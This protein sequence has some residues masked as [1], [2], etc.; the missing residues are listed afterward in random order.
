MSSIHENSINAAISSIERMFGKGIVE[1]MEVLEQKETP[2]PLSSGSVAL[3]RALGT[4]GFPRGRFVELYG[5]EASGKTVLALHTI[6]ECQKQGGRCAFIDVDHSLNFAFA[7][8]IG[9]DASKLMVVRPDY[10]EQALEV[11][12]SLARSG[13]FALI[14]LDSIGALVP[15]VEV[16]GDMGDTQVGS[17]SRLMAQACRKLAPILASTGTTFL[18]INQLRVKVG[19]FYGN[20][21]IA[22]GG[23][24]LKH[25]TSMRL[26]VRRIGAIKDDGGTVGQLTRVKVVKNLLAPPFQ[27]A[28]FSLYYNNG[29]DLVGEVLDIAIE[30]KLIPEESKGGWFRKKGSWYSYGGE[31]IGQGRENAK[32]WLREHPE[33][34]EDLL[35]QI[36][37]LPFESE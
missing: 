14:V 16:E 21:E 18:L 26:D 5:P 28:E 33:I 4:G 3:D 6:A 32:K 24:A 20:P 9:I 1:S 15:K 7:R 30:A 27:Q 2:R 8:K 11:V 23:K 25:F 12:E 29:I 10:A 13:G 36:R 35:Q 31:R 19:V 22:P 17:V 37:N 34:M